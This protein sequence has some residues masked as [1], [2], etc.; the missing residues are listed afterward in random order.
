MNSKQEL[1][2]LL[3]DTLKELGV[4]SMPEA[5]PLERPAQSTHGQYATSLALSLFSKQKKENLDF[6]YNSPR[7]FAESISIKLNEKIADKSRSQLVKSVSVAGPGF[8]N[9][10]FSN[11]F[12]FELARSLASSQE[13]VYKPSKQAGSVIIEYVSPNTNKPLHIGHV[14]NA[15]LGAAMGKILEKV[16]WN[17]HLGIINNDRGLHITKSMWAY[18]MLGQ[19]PQQSASGAESSKIPQE[20][21]QKVLSNWIVDS[22]S[23]MTPSD[24]SEER[25]QKPDHFVGYWY[26]K[27]D[28]YAEDLEVQKAWTE[29]LQAWEGKDVP[30]HTEVRQLWQ[31]LN[32]LFYIGF[33]ETCAVI[34]AV[35]DGD[36]V[37]YE[38]DIYEA[39]KEI[40]LQ[41]AEQGVFEKLPDGAV[42][43]NLEKF[44]L[45]DKILLRKDGTGIYMTF[46]IEL[47]RRRFEKKADKVVWVVGMDQQL[48]FQ[49][50]FAV[51]E[52][53]GYGNQEKFFHFAY[54]MVRL[55]E[56]KMSSR[57]GRV[58]YADDLL[59]TAQEKAKEI[60]QQVGVAKDLPP[61]E[62]SKVAQAVGIGAV[63]WTMLAQEA[64][65]EITFNIEES[66]SFTGFAG[67][68][69]QY[70]IARTHSV[71]KK[72][73][74]RSIAV[75]FDTQEVIS[76]YFDTI[77]HED[78]AELL[79]S[80]SKYF[81]V[82]E[83]SAA[84]WAPHYIATY[85]HELAQRFNTFYAHHT[86]VGTDAT[87]TQRR[88]LLTKAVQNVLT[89]G[90]KL[91]GIHP[92]ERM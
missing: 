80:L 44:K 91:L 17:V 60:M 27:G 71:F 89:E 6:S 33:K 65:S 51:A 55:P 7:E 34:G 68:Y 24:M 48:Y 19:K 30:H 25:L 86:I 73:E 66:V 3:S 77:L 82:V 21:W 40:V 70:T 62:F 69:I 2:Q 37:N 58:V 9:F 23:W 53:L 47:T 39:G 90:L 28:T 92:V 84:E 63:K 29:M 36:E 88:L 57:K 75:S 42:K 50:L 45:P 85:L 46:D 52:L 41:G 87:D 1:Q 31:H 59:E 12:Y 14:R 49:Q 43:V 72:A 18:L 8:I 10:T 26:Q 20:T 74:N 67:P 13:T 56:G 81:D 35:F 79:V 83:R 15:A 16:G 54:G 61:E 4:D 32:N 78:E 11:H 22:S 64:V 76:K 38:S 5:I